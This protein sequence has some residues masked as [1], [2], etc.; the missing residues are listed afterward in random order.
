MQANACL[1][2]TGIDLYPIHLKDPRIRYE[3][4]KLIR[5]KR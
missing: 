3:I 4:Y 2:R 1:I 5:Y